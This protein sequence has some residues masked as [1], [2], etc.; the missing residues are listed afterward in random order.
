[1]SLPLPAEDPAEPAGSDLLDVVDRPLLRVSG[2]AEIVQLVPYILGFHPTDSLVMVALRGRRV[3]ASARND[4]DAPIDLVLPWCGA[5][6]RAGADTVVAALYCNDVAGVPLPHREYVADLVALCHD[7][8]LRV[9]DVLAVSEG[10]WWSYQC[11][12][13]SCCSPDG[14]PIDQAGAIAAAAVSEG[15]VALPTRDDL[16]DELA[17]DEPEVRRVEAEVERLPRVSPGEGWSRVR[18]LVK[19]ARSGR[20]ITPRVAAGVLV[21]LADKQVRDATFGY[22]VDP[23]DQAVRDVWRQITVMSPSELRA[24]PATLY[25]IWCYAAGEGARANVGIDVALESDPQYTMSHLLLELQMTGL[26]PF[27]VVHD[28]AVEAAALGRRIA[29]G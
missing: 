2:P 18:R 27:E 26:N 16:R 22:L 12:E 17:I 14:T 7:H 21:A 6:A 3:V 11:S 13:P 29:R 1:M 8:H 25:A 20:R 5:V 9:I 23:P 19:R 28:M 24:A 4:L 10:R 15:L